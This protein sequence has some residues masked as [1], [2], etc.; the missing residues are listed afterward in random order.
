MFLKLQYS[1]IINIG[2]EELYELMKLIP[3]PL[4]ECLMFGLYLRGISPNI[5]LKDAN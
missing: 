3:K 1:N 4:K 5:Y 2:Q